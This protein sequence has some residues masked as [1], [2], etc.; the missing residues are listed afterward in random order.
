MPAVPG[1]HHAPGDK[2]GSWR[3]HRS[4]TTGLTEE[5]KGFKIPVLR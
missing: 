5:I 2:I 1:A 4:E 3:E